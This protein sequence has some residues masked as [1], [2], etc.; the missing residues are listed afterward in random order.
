MSDVRDRRSLLVRYEE[1]PKRRPQ[2]QRLFGQFTVS[3]SRKC[4]QLYW[5]SV[6]AGRSDRWQNLDSTAGGVWPNL[7]GDSEEKRTLN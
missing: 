7:S 3:E 4:R 1:F 5:D 2:L 6:L